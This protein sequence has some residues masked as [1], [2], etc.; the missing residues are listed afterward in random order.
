ML[1]IDQ[2]HINYD[3][4]DALSRAISDLF[5]TTDTTVDYPQKGFIRLRGQFLID[6]AT[7]YDKLRQRFA[8]QGF[9]PLIRKDENG[10]TVLV[11][12]QGVFEA[13]PLR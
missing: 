8:T 13:P 12:R 3:Q 4:G 10:E 1:V 2:P 6:L 7:D 11:A 9:T 5:L